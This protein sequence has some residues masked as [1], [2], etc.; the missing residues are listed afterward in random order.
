[1]GCCISGVG[2][3]TD[4]VAAVIFQSAAQF[5]SEHQIGQLAATVCPPL[6]IDY[7]AVQ[8]KKC[9]PARPVKKTGHRDYPGTGCTL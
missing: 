3:D 8:I 4:R 9:Q 7:L 6:K 1:M 2:S 5:V